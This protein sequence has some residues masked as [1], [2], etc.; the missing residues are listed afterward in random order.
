MIDIGTRRPIRLGLTFTAAQER[1]SMAF[2]LPTASLV[3]CLV[4]KPPSILRRDL[5]L[6]WGASVGRHY[7]ERFGAPSPPV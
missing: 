7:L 6:S 3:G 2:I 5:V 1:F 4:P